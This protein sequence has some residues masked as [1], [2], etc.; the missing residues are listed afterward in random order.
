MITP[1]LHDLLGVLP[2]G[3]PA[4]YLELQLSLDCS[5]GDLNSLLQFARDRGTILC[6]PLS[7]APETGPPPCVRFCSS[8]TTGQ[9]RG[10]GVTGHRR[11]CAGCP[12]A[13]GMRITPT[14]SSQTGDPGPEPNFRTMMFM[15]APRQVV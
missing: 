3:R 5:P 12:L 7:P 4:T 1:G 8:G 6:Q 14:V 10:P 11:G 15:K 13:D 9:A 2:P